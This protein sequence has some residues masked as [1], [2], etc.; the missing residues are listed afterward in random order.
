MDAD[1]LLFSYGTLQRVDM[2]L[3]TF[4]R[5]LDGDADI[6]PGYTIDYA[7]VSD[8]RTGD[9]S[10]RS[11]RPL[12]RPTGNRLDKVVG[13]ALWVTEDELEACDEYEVSLYRRVAVVLGSGRAAWAYITN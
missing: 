13:R 7:E 8:R 10:P 3:D 2:Q 6:L 1:Q 4:G 11:V 5:L 12:V 9:G